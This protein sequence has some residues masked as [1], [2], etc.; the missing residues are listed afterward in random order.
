MGAVGHSQALC[1]GGQATIVAVA[2]GQI[3]GAPPAHDQPAR[4]DACPQPAHRGVMPIEAP[5]MGTTPASQRGPMMRS[6]TTCA[7]AM[8]TA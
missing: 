6:T 5:H 3:V 1:K 7:R 2:S 4:G 8:A